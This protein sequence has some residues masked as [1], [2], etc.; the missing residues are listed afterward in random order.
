MKS[1]PIAIN[2]RSAEAV[3]IS[4]LRAVNRKKEKSEDTPAFLFHF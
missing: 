1:M 4:P 3:E 2:F